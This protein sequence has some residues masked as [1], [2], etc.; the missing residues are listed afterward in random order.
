MGQHRR[1]GALGRLPGAAILWSAVAFACLVV[2]AV[3]F[4]IGRNTLGARLEAQASPVSQQWSN[5]PEGWFDESANPIPE[6]AKK[7]AGAQTPQQVTVT[8]ESLSADKGGEKTAGNGADEAA[9]ALGDTP[10]AK[11]GAE[12]AS[13]ASDQASPSGDVGPGETGF[14]VRVGSFADRDASQRASEELTAQ[15]YHPYVTKYER[16]GETRYRVNVGRYKSR[17]EAERLK[18]EL[19][20]AGHTA[21]ISQR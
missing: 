18:Q 9:S 4:A 13:A 15:G 8:I 12:E 1:T 6:G 10:S 11:T 21:T 16:D 2:G 17:E 3:F 20:D 7:A 19:E 14:E 5:E